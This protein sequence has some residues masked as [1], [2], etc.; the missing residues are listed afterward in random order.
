[1]ANIP[2]IDFAKA[3]TG[4]D[5]EKEHTAKEVDQAF[6]N[7]GFVYLKN[8]G[9]PLDMVD[10]CFSWSKKFFALPPETKSLAPH[11]PG[12]AHHRGYSAPGVEKVSQNTYDANE[13]S[14]L[15]EI[16][17]FK[18]SFESG[19]VH[20][21]AQPNIWLPDDVLPGF[22]AFMEE[23]FVVCSHLVHRILTCLSIALDVPEPGLSSTHTQSLFQLRLLHYPAIAA[24]EL[25]TNKRSRIN[26]H[27]DFGTLTLLFQDGVGG[28]EVEDP[29]VPGQFRHAE[30]RGG[31]VL[32]NVG[33]LMARWSNDRWKSTVHRVGIPAAYA[34]DDTNSS[35]GEE[36]N[37]GEGK[38]EMVVPDRYSIPFFATADPETVVEAL[39]GCWD[40]E[41]PKRYESVTAWGY[42]QM[43]MEALYEG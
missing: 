5:Q 16:P 14:K 6:Q 33:D 12:G 27:S 25:Q 18:E 3:T 43:R 13:L 42:V 34:V 24:A 41:R 37:E 32:V 2:I 15:R 30:P 10:E 22:R 23:Y 1:M 29:R 39:P 4:T 21:T 19:N 38:G 8:H 9:V 26:A 35:I 40:E 31:T 36:N 28:L 7:V 20:D 17:D 11:P